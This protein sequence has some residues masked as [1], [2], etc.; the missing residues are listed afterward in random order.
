MSDS[1]SYEIEIRF[2]VDRPE[3]VFALLP[4]FESSLG[5]PKVWSTEILGRPLYESGRLLRLGL[6]P[7]T[8]PTR[9]YLGYKGPDLGTLANIR[10]EWDKEITNGIQDSTMLTTLGLESS[11]ADVTTLQAALTQAGHTPFMGFAGVDRLG[12][13]AP[14]GLHTKLCQC[15]AILDQ[16]YLIELEMSATSLAEARAAEAHLQAIAEEYGLLDRLFREEPPTLLYQRTFG[17]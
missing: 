4:F 8:G 10:A 17:V 15:E 1:S 6:V 7:P 9:Y 3:E 14:L 11:Y 2:C 12:Y 16:Q 13:Y 5:A